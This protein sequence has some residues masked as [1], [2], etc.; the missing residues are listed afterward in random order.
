MKRAAV[1]SWQAAKAQLAIQFEDRFIPNHHWLKHE[2]PDRSPCSGASFPP[3][4]PLG[5]FPRFLGTAKHSDFLPPLPR[6]FVSFAARY[7]RCTLSFAPADTRRSIRG[8][9]IVHRTP[10]TGLFDGDDRTS[11]VPGE[12]SMNVPCSPTPVGPSRSATTA[13]R[14]GLPP[15]GRRR[16]PRQIP[17]SGLNHTARTLAVYASQGG[18]L[19]ARLASG[20]LADLSG[21]AG[22]P[23]GPNERF[24]VISSPFP[25]LLLAHPNLSIKVGQTGLSK[26]RASGL[27][28]PP[29][30]N[31]LT[32][33][34][35]HP[36]RA[37]RAM[38][39]RSQPIP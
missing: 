21:R 3:R 7:R 26:A 33:Q 25:R 14:R 28:S 23:L 2:I 4:G 32:A 5:W 24:Q 36:T 27:N 20:W 1:D 9:G 11:Q 10:K 30:Q 17:I 13:R 39:L 12:P 37:V 22:Y 29:R 35:F 15:I 31:G 19:H 38:K 34:I 16:L 18:L 8:P 6:C